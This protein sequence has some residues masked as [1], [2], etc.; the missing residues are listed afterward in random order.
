M[1]KPSSYRDRRKEYKR[2]IH[3]KRWHALRTAYIREH[4]FCEDCL[5]NGILDQRAEEV[6]HVRPIGTGR[7]LEEMSALAYDPGNLRALCHDCHVLAHKRIDRG[8]REVSGDVAEWLKGF[9]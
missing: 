9:L 5:R 2:I 7:T 1:G 8:R 3:G 4:P 6:H